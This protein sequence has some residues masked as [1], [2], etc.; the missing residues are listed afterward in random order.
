MARERAQHVL[1]LDGAH[2]HERLA[3]ALAGRLGAREGLIHDFGGGQTFVDHDL[4]EPAEER[5]D[6]H[7]MLA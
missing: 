4:A 2:R 3:H 7:A 6:H 5:R 1:G